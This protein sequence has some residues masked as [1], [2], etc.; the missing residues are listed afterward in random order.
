M[1]LSEYNTL[2]GKKKPHKKREH[3]EDDLQEACIKWFDYQYPSLSSMMFHVP[4]GGNRNAMEGARLKKQ[5]V[6]P[7][8][9]DLILLIPRGQF[10]SCCIELKSKTGTSSKSQKAWAKECVK[11]GNDY[12]ICDNIEDFKF[13]I[14]EYLKS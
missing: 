14:D 5:G 2:F 13:L 4:N 8:V 6:R 12:N 11:Y 9:S 1:N 7:G 3:P 10:H